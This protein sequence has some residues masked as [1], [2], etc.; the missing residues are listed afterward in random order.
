MRLGRDAQ[1]VASLAQDLAAHYEVAPVVYRTVSIEG[2]IVWR[3]N[4]YSVPWRYLGQVLPV[5]ITTDE[6]VGYSPQLEEVARHRLFARSACG[7]RKL[8]S[9]W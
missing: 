5:R 6:V 8:V 9:A 4:E 3:Q 2:F 1:S 7:S